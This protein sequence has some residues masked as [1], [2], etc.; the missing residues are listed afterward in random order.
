MDWRFGCKFIAEPSPDV[1]V[2]RYSSKVLQK[3][4]L[5]MIINSRFSGLQPY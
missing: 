2:R 5:K 1:V 3:G 4:V